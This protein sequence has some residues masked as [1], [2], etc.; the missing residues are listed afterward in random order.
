MALELLRRLLEISPR[1]DNKLRQFVC[2]RTGT[3]LTGLIKTLERTFYDPSTHASRKYRGTSSSITRGVEMDAQIDEWVRDGVTPAGK[4]ARTV[5]RLLER[6][7][8]RLVATQVP[9]CDAETGVYAVA[10]GLGVDAAGRVV[11]VE[12]KSGYD[13]AYTTA[14]GRMKA[15]LD[16]VPNSYKNRHALQVYVAGLM[17]RQYGVQSV[18]CMVVVANKGGTRAWRVDAGIRAADTGIMEALRAGA[19]R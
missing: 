9:I 17:L 1:Y 14:R 8:I 18:R 19:R 6:S 11:L 5:T 16:T 7:N 12:W 10:D 3:P 13:V 4:Y 15:P 2:A